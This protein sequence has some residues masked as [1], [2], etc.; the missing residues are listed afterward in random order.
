MHFSE[1]V[2]EAVRQ[3]PLSIK[4][5]LVIRVKKCN[6]VYC[7]VRSCQESTALCVLVQHTC[8]LLVAALPLGIMH[9]C[10]L[11]TCL[12][13]WVMLQNSCQQFQPT[14]VEARLARRC[15]SCLDPFLGKDQIRVYKFK[16]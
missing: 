15:H 9:V 10:S 12:P 5:S 14:I 4:N 2:I 16:L 3:L 11:H 6:E 8:L 1:E 7:L 13:L